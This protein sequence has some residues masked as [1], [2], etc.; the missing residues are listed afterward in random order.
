MAER[1]RKS[2]TVALA[3]LPPIV[4]L[5]MNSLAWGSD[6]EAIALAYRLVT[7]VGLLMALASI[8][9]AIRQ[10]RRGGSHAV[11]GISLLI[12]LGFI[13]WVGPDAYLD[14]AAAVSGP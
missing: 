3:V 1:V 14:I 11:F 9:L 6:L 8:A 13:V 10:L 2:V 7:Y 12:A 4:L 5:T